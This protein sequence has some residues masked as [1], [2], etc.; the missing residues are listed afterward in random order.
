MAGKGGARGMK[1]K[2]EEKTE[3]KLNKF[4]IKIPAPECSST[5]PSFNSLSQRKT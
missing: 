4:Q 1:S 5:R 2:R 3:K